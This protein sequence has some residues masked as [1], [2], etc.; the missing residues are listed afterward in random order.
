MQFH[1]WPLIAQQNTIF[2][3]IHFRM[4]LCTN[5]ARNSFTRCYL[6]NN[7]EVHSKTSYTNIFKKHLH[8]RDVLAKD[9]ML[10]R[11]EASDTAGKSVVLPHSQFFI[12]PLVSSR[13]DCE[14]LEGRAVS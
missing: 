11:V 1:N 4:I 2:L 10:S 13:F 6:L 9:Q 14:Q 8:V 5:S 3:Q 7:C 12:F